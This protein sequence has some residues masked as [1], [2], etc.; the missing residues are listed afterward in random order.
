MPDA[1]RAS[2]WTKAQAVAWIA[3]RTFDAVRRASTYE[4]EWRK[5]GRPG[6]PFMCLHAGAVLGNIRDARAADKLPAPERLLRA[7]DDLETLRQNGRVGEDLSGLYRTDCIKRLFPSL[8]GRRARQGGARK[9]TRPKVRPSGVHI[10]GFQFL[11]THRHNGFEWCVDRGL[12]TTRRQYGQLRK[13]ALQFAERE[14]AL[15][16][17]GNIGVKDWKQ[18]LSDEEEAW[19][20]DN[21]DSWY[22]VGR[23][24]ARRE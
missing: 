22:C 21:L 12:V 10:L 1:A 13:L 19:C 8:E 2:R 9:A 20:R 14:L 15:R 16:K 5:D 18:P 23:P 17:W 6:N 4:A 11:T 3:F 24:P 7:M